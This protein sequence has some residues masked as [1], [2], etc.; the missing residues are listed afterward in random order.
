MSCHTCRCYMTHGSL[1]LLIFDVELLGENEKK[2]KKAAFDLGGREKKKKVT[3]ELAIL[4][5]TS[6]NA[7]S[8]W[9]M[10]DTSKTYFFPFEG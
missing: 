9:R 8:K 2:R 7:T 3:F 1:W 6:V 5:M 10:I 4:F